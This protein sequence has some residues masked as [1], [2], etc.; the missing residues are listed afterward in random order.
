VEREEGTPMTAIYWAWAISAAGLVALAVLLGFAMRPPRVPLGIL[1]D[2]RGRYSLTQFQLVVWSIVVLS[3][4][5]GIFWGRLIDGVK[6]PLSFSIPSQVLGLL[7]ISTG[8]AVT[9]ITVKAAKDATSAAARIAASG[10]IGTSGTVDAPRFSQIFLMEEGAFADQVIDVTKYQN[11]IITLVLVVAYVALAIH[12]IQD[13]KTAAG[14]NSL[15]SFSGTFLVL[16]GISHAAYIAGK[17]PN[18]DGVPPG[19]TVANRSAPPANIQA[20][21]QK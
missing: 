15:P 9:A 3:L 12:Q 21:N 19:L 18:Q 6:D 16:L 8:S 2:S 10:S 13:A 1:I 7:G 20:R 11:F 14:V 17:L 5:S 4:V